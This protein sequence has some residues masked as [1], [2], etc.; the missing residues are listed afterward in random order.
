M[1]EAKIIEAVTKVPDPWATL[2]RHMKSGSGD[3]SVFRRGL[4]IT[5]GSVK[6]CVHL[7]LECVVILQKWIALA[8]YH[9]W[10]NP[11]LDFNKRVAWLQI[12]ECMDFMD[13]EIR[14][15]QELEQIMKEQSIDLIT[16]DVAISL[17]AQDNRECCIFYQPFGVAN[18][19]GV[20]ETPVKLQCGGQH[21][22]GKQC[23]A[24]WLK[25]AFSCPLDRGII[26][27]GGPPS[28]LWQLQR[29]PNWVHQLLGERD[30]G[31]FF[32]P[33]TKEFLGDEFA[34]VFQNRRRTT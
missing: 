31:D 23:L 30:R 24:E 11:A 34:K 2:K 8:R 12:R 27:G 28:P 17:L 6:R 20:A 1:R 10:F 9:F 29:T 4:Y 7:N 33:V 3:L 19:D 5:V 15:K 21:V 32:H 22:F 14:A 18:D 26:C 25:E 13:M 16:K